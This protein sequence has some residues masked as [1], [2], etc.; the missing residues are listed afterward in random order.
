[1]NESTGTTTTTPTPEAPEGAPT[2]SISF[3]G[4][5][6]VPSDPGL[7]FGQEITGTFRARIDGVN[8]RR[9]WKGNPD[10]TARVSVLGFELGE[11]AIVQGEVVRSGP[12]LPAAPKTRLARIGA[13]WRRFSRTP[14]GSG[15]TF[16]VSFVGVYVLIYAGFLLAARLAG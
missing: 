14:A 12:M 9:D 5:L 15:I 13:A 10:Y 16:G 6:P 11:V 4:I 2:Y 1:V 7:V 8:L 3:D